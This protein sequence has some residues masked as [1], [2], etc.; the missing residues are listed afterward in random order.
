MRIPVAVLALFLILKFSGAASGSEQITIISGTKYR[1][2]KFVIV[3]GL[4]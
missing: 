1:P 3:T 2:T 4:P